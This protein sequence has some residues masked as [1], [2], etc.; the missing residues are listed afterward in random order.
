MTKQKTHTERKHERAQR[1]KLER[2]QNRQQGSSDAKGQDAIPLVNVRLAVSAVLALLTVV[3]ALKAFEF[4]IPN[5][6]EPTVI[7]LSGAG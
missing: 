7:N 3:L 6:D 2:K 1:R 4:P 5:A